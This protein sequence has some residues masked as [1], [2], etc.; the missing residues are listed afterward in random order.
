MN[1][2][3]LKPNYIIVYTDIVSKTIIGGRLS[4]I[5]KIVPI[6]SNNTDTYVISDFKHKEYYELQNTEI[7]SIEI[8][9]RSHDGEL[10]NFATNQS[11]ILNLEFSNYYELIG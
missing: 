4:N 3:Y 2:D 6:K 7:T 8:N 9:L 11:T 10:V 5:L 1:L